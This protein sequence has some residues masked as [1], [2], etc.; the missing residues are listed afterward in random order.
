MLSSAKI[1]PTQV[2]Q[3]HQRDLIS[4]PHEFQLPATVVHAARVGQSLRLSALG[5]RFGSTYIRVAQTLLTLHP[6]LN[7]IK[8]YQQSC[9]AFQ[10]LLRS[11]GSLAQAN[12]EPPFDAASSPKTNM[13]IWHLKCSSQSVIIC[14]K[15]K[16]CQLGKVCTS[17]T[18]MRGHIFKLNMKR[19]QEVVKRSRKKTNQ[20]FVPGLPHY[21]QIRGTRGIMLVVAS[22]VPGDCT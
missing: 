5:L 18:Q 21:A 12:S 15:P 16:I 13:L 22:V 10:S 2:D 20:Q 1:R 14:M 6:G 9:R 17:Q 19:L 8:A 3:K 7:A 11:S 4:R